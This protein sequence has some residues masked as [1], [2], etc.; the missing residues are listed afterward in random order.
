MGDVNGEQVK[1]PENKPQ[2][3]E[4]SA[5]ASQVESLKNDVQKYSVQV[6]D[7]SLSLHDLQMWVVRAIQREKAEVCH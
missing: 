2:S 1:G 5:L 4:T 6:N 7:L 3:E